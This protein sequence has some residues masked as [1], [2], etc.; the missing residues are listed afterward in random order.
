MKGNVKLKRV[1][2]ILGVVLSPTVR[3]K[4]S[5]TFIANRN[6]Y[7]NLQILFTQRQKL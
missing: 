1:W 4:I 6:K 7:L 5:R 2:R 3:K